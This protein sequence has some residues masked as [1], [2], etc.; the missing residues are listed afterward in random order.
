MP[1][2]IFR[3]SPSPKLRTM[4][5]P[6]TVSS[7]TIPLFKGKCARYSYFYKF[8]NFGRE[9]GV[10]SNNCVQ[11]I[12]NFCLDFIEKLQSTK[13]FFLILLQAEHFYLMNY[14]C[15]LI[16]DYWLVQKSDSS[17]LWRLGMATTWTMSESDGVYT[18]VTLS[19]QRA[20]ILSG[21]TSKH[22]TISL[23]SR[24]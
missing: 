7:L 16:F 13:N 19:K 21:F 8:L 6:N 20:H 12:A 10:L 22:T 5:H 3:R 9:C 23:I 17:K 14:L 18:L 4:S 15:L 24:W 11:Q 2:K 1:F